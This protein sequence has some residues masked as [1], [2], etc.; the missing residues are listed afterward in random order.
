M[1]VLYFICCLVFSQTGLIFCRCIYVVTVCANEKSGGHV[2]WGH[3][4]HS[5]LLYF[6]RC[7][8]FSLTVLTF[9][10][11]IYV[12]TAFFWKWWEQQ[13][14]RIRRIVK[15]LVREGRL[16]FI[17]GSWS[18]HDEATTHYHSIV[19]GFTWGFR[20]VRS[21]N[22]QVLIFNLGKKF[23]FLYDIT[24]TNQYPG[25]INWLRHFY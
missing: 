13:P 15:R 14:H 9:R 6:I 22:V 24:V 8:V 7:I 19:D 1:V 12:E 16:E 2:S 23:I 10:R 18:M 21:L 5:H 3:A 4:T 17:G 20:L 25:K 11:F